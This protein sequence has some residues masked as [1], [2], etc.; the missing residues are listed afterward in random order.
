MSFVRR[1]NPRPTSSSRRGAVPDQ[2]RGACGPTVVDLW[3]DLKLQGSKRSTNMNAVGAASFGD[4]ARSDRPHR[5]IL[6]LRQVQSKP[7]PEC[8]RPPENFDIRQRRR[9][10]APLARG[11][12][13]Q[14]F[15][16]AMASDLGASLTT[17][18]LRPAH[19]P[20]AP[21]W[22]LRLMLCCRRQLRH[23]SPPTTGARPW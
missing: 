22:R 20:P 21:A 11:R 1:C 2:T 5:P 4:L 19:Q 15:S 6:I 13:R 9:R 10:P 16:L 14:C 3:H 8:A 12:R 18:V 7:L 23:S 17:A